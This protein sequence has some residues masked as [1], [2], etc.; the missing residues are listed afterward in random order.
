MEIIKVGEKTIPVEKE[1]TEKYKKYGE[2]DVKRFI[3]MMSEEGTSVIIAAEMCHIPHSS[4]YKFLDQWDASNRTVY[5]NMCKP[6]VKPKEEDDGL[7][8]GNT[9]FNKYHTKYLIGLIDASPC[10]AVS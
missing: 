7:L 6:K 9:K 2:E 8:T 3:D 1:P 4:A 10:I 5:S